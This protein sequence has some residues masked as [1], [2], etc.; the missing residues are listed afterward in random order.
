M[1]RLI[2]VALLLGVL[3]G[4]ATVSAQPFSFVA[5]G[6]AP[7]QMPEGVTQVERLIARINRQQPAFTIHVGD[8]KNGHSRCDD[9][10]MELIRKLFAT[11][12][13]PLVY[14]PGDNEWTDCHRT[15]NG[16]YDPLERLARVREVFYPTPGMSLGRAPMQL[17]TQSADPKFTKFVEN[18]RWEKSGVQ[19]ATLHVIGSNNNLQR[20]PAAANEYFERN[21]ANVA[22]LNATFARAV[23]GYR[24]F[25]CDTMSLI[26]VVSTLQE[27]TARVTG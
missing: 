7:Y 2:K 20:N 6:D 25:K 8:I 1:S 4:N 27:G 10:H 9:A 17:D 23:Q 14:T 16:G 22:W 12:A 11:F 21:A 24:N 13:Q 18:S 26:Q 3:F 15:D 19:F 5:I